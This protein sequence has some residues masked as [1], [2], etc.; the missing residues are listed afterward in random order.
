MLIFFFVSFGIYGYI[1]II[2]SLQN[3]CLTV[4]IVK[5]LLWR[6]VLYVFEDKATKNGERIIQQ[7]HKCCKKKKKKVTKIFCPV[8]YFTISSTIPKFSVKH[9]TCTSVSKFS[10]VLVDRKRR[11]SVVI[12]KANKANTVSKSIYYCLI[13]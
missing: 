10:I 12:W 6:S 7:L 3:S 1:L 13:I 5:L 9:E 11:N 4:Q 8:M 2:N